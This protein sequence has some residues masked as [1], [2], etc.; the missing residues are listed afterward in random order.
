MAT[1]TEK[2]KTPTF[3]GRIAIGSFPLTCRTSLMHAISLVYVQLLTGNRMGRNFGRAKLSAAYLHMANTIIS[4]GRTMPII[5][6]A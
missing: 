5:A 3:N 4:D 1:Q 6:N 2:K